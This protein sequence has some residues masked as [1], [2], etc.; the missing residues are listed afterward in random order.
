MKLVMIVMFGAF[1]ATWGA[2]QSDVSGPPLT[3]GNS[4][5]ENSP[6]NMHQNVEHGDVYLEEYIDRYDLIRD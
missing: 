3:E 6:D 2:C 1:V 5:V 4:A